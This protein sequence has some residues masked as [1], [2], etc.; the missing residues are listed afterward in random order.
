MSYSLRAALLGALDRDLASDGA[1]DREAECLDGACEC[2]D[3]A[4][5]ALVPEAEEPLS[6][7]EVS[8]STSIVC[9]CD[10]SLTLLTVPPW[11]LSAMTVGA[12]LW[13]P[14]WWV[15]CTLDA[16]SGGGAGWNE[17]TDGAAAMYVT[18]ARG[19]GLR[20]SIMI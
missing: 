12:W 6:L 11:T 15:S 10:C 20:S 13:C 9:E 3:L 2:R 14:P 7:P 19:E 1:R 5:F 8:S 18:D 4:V 16:D 17:C